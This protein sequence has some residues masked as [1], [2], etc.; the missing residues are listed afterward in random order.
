MIKAFLF[1][2]DGV[3]TK[4]VDVK[5]PSR[6]LASNLG[7]SVEKADGLIRDVWNKYSVGGISVD[8]I[9]RDIETKLGRKVPADKRNIWH[10]W[11]ELR[12][13]PFMLELVQELRKKGCPVGL[14][15]NV[16]KETADSI[17]AHGGYDSFDFTILSCEAKVRKPDPEIYA[18]AMEKL[19]GIKPE[20]VLFLDDREHCIRGAQSFGLQT[21]HVTDHQQAIERVRDLIA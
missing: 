14:L 3:I 21:I 18:L 5:L 20:E 13:L 9:W 2:Y 17:R 11:E 10:T 12:P 7:I 6:R 1:D 15:S 4:G 16:F 19:P 8:E